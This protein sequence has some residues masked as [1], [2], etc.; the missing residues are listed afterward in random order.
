MVGIDEVVSWLG[1]VPFDIAWQVEDVGEGVTRLSIEDPHA[2]GVGVDLLWAG[3]E[4]VATFGRGTVVDLSSNMAL[5]DLSTLLVELLGNPSEERW[6]RSKNSLEVR[7]GTVSRRFASS[8][9]FPGWT[10]GSTN[11]QRYLPYQGRT[12]NG[13]GGGQ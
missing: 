11:T 10:R 12:R 6:S 9:R 7:S 1:D 13:N 3:R 5:G 2:R 4:L 8:K